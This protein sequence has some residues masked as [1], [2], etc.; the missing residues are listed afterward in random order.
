MPSGIRRC[1]R[2]KRNTLDLVVKRAARKAGIAQ[3]REVYPHCL[4]KAFEGAL[5]NAGLDVKDQ[6]FL[7]GHILPGT[8]DTYYDKTKV[9]YLRSRYVK[10][11][12]FP[13]RGYLTENSRKRQILDTA[14][15]L[16]YS[17]DK[18]KRIEEALAKYERVDDALEQIK[19]LNT[20]SYKQAESQEERQ[21]KL[22]GEKRQ[23]RMVHGEQTLIRF[24]N[25]GW[26]LVEKLADEKF[27]MQKSF[28]PMP[29][30]ASGWAK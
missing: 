15:I 9:E 25:D 23:V 2:A 27:V 11:N 1:T 24:M 5:R 30:R 22:L 3:W 14:K 20:D 6:E 10:V 28:E 8:Q 7:M 4:R 29:G 19:K 17:E 18:I 12:F 21:S 13:E 16:G 26:D